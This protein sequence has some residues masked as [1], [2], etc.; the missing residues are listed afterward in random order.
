MAERKFNLLKFKNWL[1]NHGCE[2]LPVTN[3]Y[4]S[5]RW[6]GKKVGVIYHS[7]KNSG[8]YAWGAIEA[9]VKRKKWDG[10]PVTTGRYNHYVKEKKLLLERDGSR[11][12]FCGLE[13]E[14]D[15]TLEHL[16]ALSR[17]GKNNLSNMVLAHEECNWKTSRLNISEKVNIAI[18]NRVELKLEEYGRANE[19]N[20]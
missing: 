16:I 7:G 15:I 11:C 20:Y 19:K 3:E 12:F 14:D 17:G 5:L 18:K 4:E 13:M 8:S 9:Y 10:G 1:V 6:K 2:I